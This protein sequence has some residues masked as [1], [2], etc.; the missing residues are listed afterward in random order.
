VKAEILEQVGRRVRE[1][2]TGLGWSQREL[3]QRAALS[4]RFLGQLE[5]G[6]GNISLGRF[7]AVADALGVDMVT[8]LR[9][10]PTSGPAHV[11]LLGLRGA[12]KSTIGKRL[13]RELG[14][15]FVE[16]DD[17][18]ARA[19]SLS[20]AELF[21]LHGEAYYL[22]LTRET[23]RRFLAEAPSSVVATGGSIVHDREAVRLLSEHTLTVWL[24]ARPEDH[25]NRVVRQGDR[26]P[27]AEH[28]QAFA[29]LQA[30]L[31]ARE[32]LYAAARLTVD[33]SAMG[34]D[35]AVSHIRAAARSL[36][37]SATVGHDDSERPPDPRPGGVRRL[38]G[39]AGR[40]EQRPSRRAPR[41]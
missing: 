3:A 10:T 39:D 7:A 41:P 28:P 21:Q 38:G 11:A 5:H 33:T 26:R 13:A 34:I 27:M 37:T 14:V 8:L 25:W 19:A 40:A 15:P 30:L 31:A 22:R 23:L 36:V 4:V 20:L 32:P 16:L 2:R 29:E 18:V 24:K 35:G 6:A 17:W 12:G 9:P 1:R